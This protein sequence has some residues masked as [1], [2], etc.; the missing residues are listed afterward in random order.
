[1]KTAPAGLVSHLLANPRTRRTELWTFTLVDGQV[2][3][4][5]TLDRS[6]TIDSVTWQAGGP[7]LRRPMARLVVGIEVDDFEINVEPGPA[8]EIAGVPW[9]LAGRLG[10]LRNGRVL[11][12]R[13]YFATHAEMA[14][15]VTSLGKLYHMSGRM[16]G[17]RGDGASLSIP[18]RSDFTLLNAS[19]PPDIAQPTCRY[20]L[21][22]LDAPPQPRC[23]LDAEDFKVS[24]TAAAGSTA[25][26]VQAALSEDDGWFSLG[27]IVF[28]GGPNAGHSRSVKRHADGSP[29]LL[30]LVNAFPFA[31][32]TGDAFDLYPGCDK[33]HTTC[34]AK[35][36][37]LPNFGAEPFIPQPEAAV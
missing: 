10:I 14:A 6:V 19:I 8:E 13:A 24:G 1:V 27:R 32:G 4:Y 35:F 16:G 30:Q 17:V 22:D 12:E 9:V 36:G 26:I 37:N 34:G 5:T 7:V 2:A 29:A 15:G 25:R 11:I 23:T 28:T 20:T 3:R 31:P 21:F 33:L 18:C